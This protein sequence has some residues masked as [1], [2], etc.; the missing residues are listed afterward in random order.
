VAHNAKFDGGILSWVYGVK[1]AGYICTQSMAR[2]VFNDGVKSHSL[3]NIAAT[4]R[5]GP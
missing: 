1:P 4:L 2:A 5:P 3:A